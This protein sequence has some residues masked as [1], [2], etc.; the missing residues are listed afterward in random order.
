MGS[1][2]TWNITRH[3]LDRFVERFAPE[4]PDEEALSRMRALLDDAVEVGQ[5]DTGRPE[6]RGVLMGSSDLSAAVFLCRP[7]ALS[8]VPGTWVCV[9]TLDS[10]A[11][12]HSFRGSKE[13]RGGPPRRG[14]RGG[15]RMRRR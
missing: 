6:D 2:R 4:S 14:A 3:A 9:T 1:D 13:G 12:Q 5:R 10:P 8:S 11:H 15:G 7:D